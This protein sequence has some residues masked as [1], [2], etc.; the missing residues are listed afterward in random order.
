MLAAVRTLRSGLLV[1]GLGGAIAVASAGPAMAAKTVM[2]DAVSFKGPVN[3]AG[4]YAASSCKVKSDG[5]KTVFPCSVAGRALGIGGPTIEV[6][7]TWAGPDGEGFF[8][9]LAAPLVASK[10]PVTTYTGTG[11]CVE[12]E[13]SDLPGTAGPVEYPCTVTV[14][15][16]F[17]SVK[18]TVTGTYTVREE[19]TQP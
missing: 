17:N 9:P 6:T 3:A 10:P 2:S 15:L 13:E 18:A 11:P 4:E 5:E 16:T 7:S 8:P 14:K 12:R 1:A 19:S